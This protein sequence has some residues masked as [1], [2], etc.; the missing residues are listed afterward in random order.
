MVAEKLGPKNY[1]D[2]LDNPLAF[3]D[4]VK[5]I[6]SNNDLKAQSEFK[7]WLLDQWTKIDS[8]IS[9]ASYERVLRPYNN[10]LKSITKTVKISDKVSLSESLLS[11][12]AFGGPRVEIYSGDNSLGILSPENKGKHQA[13][14]SFRADSKATRNLTT[15]FIENTS[16][17]LDSEGK[18]FLKRIGFEIKVSPTFSV[19]ELHPSEGF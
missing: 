12:E 14:M 17:D 18:A 2:I 3:I 15:V 10:R 16:V 1:P 13:R 7:E 9:Q 11:E 5:D 4:Q 19:R 6:S 8:Q